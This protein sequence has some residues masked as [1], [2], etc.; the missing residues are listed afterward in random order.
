MAHTT[1]ITPGPARAR[2][3]G[4]RVETAEHI[5]P[6]DLTG[7]R[8]SA[9]VLVA[10]RLDSARTLLEDPALTP[11]RRPDRPARPHPADPPP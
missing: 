8:P 11:G 9:P 10:N 5:G 1:G 2:D 7:L 4:V 6:G 3:P